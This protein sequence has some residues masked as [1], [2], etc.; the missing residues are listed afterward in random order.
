MAHYLKKRSFGLLLLL[1]MP[2]G[3]QA[4]LLPNCDPLP[5]EGRLRP[6]ADCGVEHLFELIVNVYNFALGLAALVAF[7]FIVIGGVRML[8]A[9]YGDGEGNVR[10]AKAT[11]RNGIVGF[12]IVLAAYLIVQTL[13]TFLGVSS[14]KQQEYFQGRV[15]NPSEQPKPIP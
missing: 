13:L 3:A 6:G 14:T 2:L 12:V 5:G 10:D 8:I 11:L 15:F 4:A 9:Y 7:L 1:L